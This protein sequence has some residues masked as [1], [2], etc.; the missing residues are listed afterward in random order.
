[1]SAAGTETADVVVVGGG[2]IAAGD[3]ILDTAREFVREHALPPM[4]ETP[5]RLAA[6]GPDAGMIGA[7]LLG[8]IGLEGHV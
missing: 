7:A 6:L 2:A 4:D 5:I 8:R 3:L 1:M